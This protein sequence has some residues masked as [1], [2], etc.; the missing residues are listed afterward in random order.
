MINRA[1]KI[2]NDTSTCCIQIKTNKAFSLLIFGAN[3]NIISILIFAAMLICLH[4][5]KKFFLHLRGI[6][7]SYPTVFF[8]KLRRK[9]S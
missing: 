3:V 6:V 9:F 2:K 1:Y 8:T 4:L 5:L 7:Y